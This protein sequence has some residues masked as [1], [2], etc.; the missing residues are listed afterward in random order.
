MT[1]VT[2]CDNYEVN[3]YLK[4]ISKYKH[5]SNEEELA[6]GKQIKLGSE[7][8]KM[9]IVQ[10]NLKNVVIIAKKIVHKTNVPMMDLIQE[11]NLGLMVAVEKFNWDYGTKFITYATWWIRQA[12]FK[13]ISEQSNSMKIPV[14]VQE[15]LSKF[16]KVKTELEQQYGCCVQNSEVAKAMNISETKIDE[17]LNAF[18]KAVSIDA[19]FDMA[20][21]KSAKIA[22]ILE[23]LA[24][25]S[26]DYPDDLYECI[27]YILTV[28]PPAALLPIEIKLMK[29]NKK[30]I[31]F[32]FGR[33][34]FMDKI[35][36]YRL[37]KYNPDLYKVFTLRYG[38][39]S[40]ALEN[41]KD[42]CLI[43]NDFF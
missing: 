37:N 2:C 38:S 3:E 34:D 35:G 11:G 26:L 28:P 10:S 8:A 29:L 1:T 7:D 4:M 18:N 43:I 39:H 36:A 40:F 12:I 17:Y 30:Q 42:L 16:S 27:Y 20:D 41:P 9:M 14:Y 19:E 24:I 25:L 21:G 23:K 15:T 5:L 31:I 32:V 6:L 22:E 33:D 13:A